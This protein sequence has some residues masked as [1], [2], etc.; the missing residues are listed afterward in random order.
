MGLLDGGFVAVDSA[1]DEEVEDII[2]RS[3]KGERCP[4]VADE[5]RFSLC[6]RWGERDE[7]EKVA[8]LKI[9]NSIVVR[10]A[11][12]LFLE[13]CGHRCCRSGRRR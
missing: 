3:G 12:E 8:W 10:K 13:E 11:A 5:P 4:M 7:E 2:S 1:A 6:R 9:T